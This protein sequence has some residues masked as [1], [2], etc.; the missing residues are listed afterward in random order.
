MFFAKSTIII[1]SCSIFGIVLAFTM[2]QK[3]DIIDYL[4]RNKALFYKQ[5]SVVKIGVFGSY[6]RDEQTDNSDIDIIIDMPKGTENIFEK[7]MKLKETIS[8]HFSMPVDVC[9]ERAIKP[10]FRDLILK[11]VIYV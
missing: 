7:R 2:T 6:A 4:E 3:K 5:F 1:L 11:D 10:F 8:N 9:H